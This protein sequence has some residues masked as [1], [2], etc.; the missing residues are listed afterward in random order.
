MERATVIAL[1]ENT[2]MLALGRKLGFSFKRTESLSETE[3][4]IDLRKLPPAGEDT[5]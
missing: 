5:G 2:Q 3:L 4:S 1:A